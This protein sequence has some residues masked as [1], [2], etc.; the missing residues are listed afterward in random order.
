MSMIISNLLELEVINATLTSSVSL[1]LYGNN[2]TPTGND[3]VGA[4]TEIAGGGY[5]S[6]TLTFASWT[7]QQTTPPSSAVNVSQEW[8]F[9]GPIDAPGTIYGYYVVRISDSKLLWA[10]RFP[11]AIVPFAPIAGSK[12]VILPKFTAESQF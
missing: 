11:P 5:A 8:V 9:T 4:F 7:I 10:E 3:V 2:V 1:R 12:I 6:K